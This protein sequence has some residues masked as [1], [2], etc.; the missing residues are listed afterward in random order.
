MENNKKNSTIAGKQN[1]GINNK[2]ILQILSF[3]KL[4]FKYIFFTALFSIISMCIAE[5][6]GRYIA[7]ILWG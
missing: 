3:I 1:S 5:I 4:N 7:Y 2:F 6:V